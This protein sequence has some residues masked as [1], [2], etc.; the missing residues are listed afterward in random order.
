MPIYDFKCDR[1]GEVEER[2][3]PTQHGEQSCKSCGGSMEQLVS[4][5]KVHTFRE[6]WYPNIDKKDLYI[7]SKKQLK[8]ECE[9]RGL[10]SHYASD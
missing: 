2:L 1:C 4:A 3:L 8:K 6:G 7:S 9:K 5:P 10:T